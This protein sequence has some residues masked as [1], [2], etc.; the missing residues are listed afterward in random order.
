MH[1]QQNEFPSVDD[2][3]LLLNKIKLAFVDDPKIFQEFMTTWMK[4]T[5]NE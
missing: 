2:V 3:L 4:Y 1:Q 5:L